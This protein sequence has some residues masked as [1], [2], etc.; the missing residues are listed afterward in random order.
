MLW[1][2]AAREKYEDGSAMVRYE[3][4]GCAY[5]IESRRR[6]IRHANGIG[7]WLYTSYWLISTD[8]TEKEFHSLQDAK[9]AAEKRMKENERIHL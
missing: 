5:A 4:E 8:G 7:S 1:R 9:E 3:A 6:P 2:A